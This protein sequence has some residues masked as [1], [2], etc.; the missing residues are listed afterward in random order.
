[1]SEIIKNVLRGKVIIQ[2]D[3]VIKTGMHI[4]GGNDYAPIGSVDS[5]FVRDALTQEPIIPGSSLKGKIRTLLARYRSKQYILNSITED[6]EIIKRLFG[7]TSP[8]VISRLQFQ[9]LFVSEESKL[10]FESIETDTYMGEVKFEN[11]INRVSSV[12]M[13]RQIERVPAGTKFVFQLVYTVIDET[14]IE[15]DLKTLRAG[16]KLLELDYLGGH[17]TRG[18][19]RVSIEN[20]KVTSF[21]DNDALREQC[22]VILQG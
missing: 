18:Y 19:G 1:M 11:T 6:D 22:E 2:G 5:P 7:S 14:E 8:Q 21:P 9:D 20:I 4:G 10:L 16:I 3:L 15:E 13:P 17:G 12:A